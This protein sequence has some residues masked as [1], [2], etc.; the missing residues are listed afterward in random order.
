MSFTC[1]REIKKANEEAGQH[2]FSEGAINFFNSKFGRRIYGGRYFISSEAY[3]YN[4]PRRYTIREAEEDGTVN[5]VG[6]FQEF[7]N[8]SQALNRIHQ[9]L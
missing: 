7:D 1:I 5:T 8:H 6:E 3:D 4:A 9:M 2:W